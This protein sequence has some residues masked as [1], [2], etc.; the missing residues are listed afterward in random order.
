MIIF[1]LLKNVPSEFP[2]TYT[3]VYTDTYLSKQIFSF[4]LKQ[5]SVLGMTFHL[6][7]QSILNMI[8]SCKGTVTSP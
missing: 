2:G 3:H 6:N 8:L 5:T 4:K 1:V 7:S